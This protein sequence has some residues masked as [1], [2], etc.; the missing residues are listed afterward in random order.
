MTYVKFLF[1]VSFLF[2]LNSNSYC[3]EKPPAIEVIG[4]AT[5]SVEPDIMKWTL[6]I[7]QD[8][9]NLQEAVN[10]HD[11]ALIKVLNVLKQNGI[12][13]SKI[14]TSGIRM[15]KKL[16]RYGEEKKFGVNNTVWFTSDKIEKY[17]ALS[18]ELNKIEDVYITETDLEYSK[19]IETRIQARTNALN[20]AKEKAS[21]MAE[22][23]GVTI[24]KPL[25][26]SEAPADYWSPV[27]SNVNSVDASRQ[28][29]G[30]SIL[31]SE[32]MISIEAR[33]KVIFEIK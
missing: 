9:D 7:Q 20:A 30:S 31:F 18:S 27:Q 13:E 8:N 14:K 6:N 25:F 28:Y 23:Y 19:A 26:I 5:I 24:G 12:E 21:K 15:T 16:Y 17:D 10:K 32:G 29:S 11:A 33:V 4:T 1:A 2:L 3:Q 22:V